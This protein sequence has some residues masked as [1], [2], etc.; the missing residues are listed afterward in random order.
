VHLSRHFAPRGSLGGYVELHSSVHAVRLP[1]Q[2]LNCTQALQASTFTTFVSLQIPVVV[3]DGVCATACWKMP[4]A[5]ATTHAAI[6]REAP[7]IILTLLIAGPP[8]ACADH[9][10]KGYAPV[11]RCGHLTTSGAE[12]YRTYRAHSTRRSHSRSQLVTR[13]R[14]SLNYLPHLMQ[15]RSREGLS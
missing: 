12:R 3:S 4:G 15:N 6:T 5:N 2:P 14:E 1:S 10:G 8:P 11:G 13:S 9:H 7:E